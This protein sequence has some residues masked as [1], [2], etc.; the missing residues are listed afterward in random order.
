MSIESEDILIYN[1]LKGKLSEKENADFIQRVKTD[2]DFKEKFSFEK[3]LYQ[4]LNENEW[5]FLE[6]KTKEVKEYKAIFEN[7]TI[8]TIKEQLKTENVLYQNSENKKH[9]KKIFYYVAAA[10]LALL[11]AVYQIVLPKDNPQNLI[12]NYIENTDLPSISVRGGHQN[13][14]TK[15]QNLFENKK[16]KEALLIFEKELQNPKNTIATIYLYVGVS[17]LKLNRL[18]EA[19]ITFNTLINSKL[20]D[21]SKGYWYKALLYVKKNEIKESKDLLNKIIISKW[22]NYKQAKKLLEELK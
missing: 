11:I 10:V 8:K 5:S 18:D 1:F 19:E 14:L 3:E 12:E 9:N 21:S 7:D 2:S 15:A 20:L 6:A 16:Y 22:Y 13:E 17:Q 4:S